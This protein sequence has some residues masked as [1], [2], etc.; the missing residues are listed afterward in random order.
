ML[1]KSL[2]VSA[3]LA[4]P[5]YAYTPQPVQTGEWEDGSAIAWQCSNKNSVQIR[6]MFKTPDGTTYQGVLGCGESV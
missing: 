2:L 6:F 1:L 3:A 5:V 4:A